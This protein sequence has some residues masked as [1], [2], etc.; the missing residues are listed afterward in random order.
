MYTFCV[1]GLHPFLCSFIKFHLLNKKKRKENLKRYL[2]WDRPVPKHHV[3]KE[4]E[5][6]RELFH[7]L[8]ERL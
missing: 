6:A 4:V 2:L 1:L 5:G 7:C 8:D 3:W